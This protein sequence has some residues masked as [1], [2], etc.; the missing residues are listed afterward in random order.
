L[1]FTIEFNGEALFSDF[2]V[3]GKGAVYTFHFFC[4]QEGKSK[5][6]P[7]AEKKNAKSAAPAN[8]IGAFG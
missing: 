3:V 5:P 8:S 7:F 2:A 6:A 1:I 4:I